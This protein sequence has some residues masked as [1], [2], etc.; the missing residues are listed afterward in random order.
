MAFYPRVEILK[1]TLCGGETWKLWEVDQ[2]Y[3]GSFEMWY[4]SW[5]EKISWTDHLRN[6]VLHKVKKERYIIHTIKRRAYWIGRVLHR[7][8]LLKYVVEEKLEA[9]IE[10]MGRRGRRRKQLLYDL[11]QRRGY[12][13]LQE[14]ALDRSVWRTG[15]GRG[16]GHIV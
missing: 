7:N 1:R 6:E 9:R 11:K 16:Y 15:I 2:K 5:V 13:K 8:C 10:A 3:L 14:E 12:L 4:W